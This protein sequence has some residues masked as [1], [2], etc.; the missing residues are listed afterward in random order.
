MEYW[1]YAIIAAV[2][3]FII[4]KQTATYKN[5][6]NNDEQQ[7]YLRDGGMFAFILIIFVA[8]SYWLNVGGSIIPTVPSIGFNN[9]KETVGGINKEFERNMVNSI[10]QDVNVSFE[11][12]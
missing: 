8:L 4:I 12:F 10:R 11:P 1:G 2:V 7:S 9:A 3:C 6:V 5:K